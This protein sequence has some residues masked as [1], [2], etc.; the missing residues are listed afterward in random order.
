MRPARVAGREVP[1]EEDVARADR[2]DGL[3]PLGTH[4]VETPLVIAPNERVA[5][6]LVGDDRLERATLADAVQSEEVVLA[7][8]EL[9]PDE[10]LGLALVRRDQVRPGAHR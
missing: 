6:F 7:I 4:L 3:E 5:A 1:R 2:R 10:L 9:V 8:A